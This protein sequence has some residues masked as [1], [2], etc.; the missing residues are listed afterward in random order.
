LS[1]ASLA[2]W[3][4]LTGRCAGGERTGI[5]AGLYALLLPLAHRY[6][7]SLLVDPFQAALVGA[8]LYS[9]VRA[10]KEGRSLLPVT[11]LVA[12]AGAAK[13]TSLLLAASLLL[14]LLSDLWRPA[15]EGR[16]TRSE[17]WL[18]ALLAL[19]PLLF[20]RR[21]DLTLLREMSYW[22]SLPLEWADLFRLVPVPL[23]IL[24]LLA[25]H[26]RCRFPGVLRGIFLF[27]LVWLAFFFWRRG[28]MNWL[29]PSAVPLAVL[30]AHA[31]IV[32]VGGRMRVIAGAGA[33]AALLYGGERSVAEIRA[34][35][36]RE[37]IYSEA[38]AFVDARVPPGG[39]IAVDALPFTGSV[40]LRT[41]T[42]DVR[43]TSFRD[44]SFA[45]LLPW[46]FE[47]YKIRGF[48]GAAWGEV[49]ETEVRAGWTLEKR[50]FLEGEPILEIYA[51]PKP[52]RR[53]R[54]ATSE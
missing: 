15:A 28:Q 50:Y 18:F 41:E 11:L 29:L 27:L 35:R 20:V 51:N 22:R 48:S 47:N 30:A 43:G 32:H 2:P 33:I 8:A 10:E 31:T 23:L 52:A 34:Y 21:G 40:Y 44:A 4:Y 38:G 54:G 24:A 25:P 53:S 37:R 3:A 45:L 26:P 5:L 7:T 19:S 16:R 39:I 49:H 6:G 46:V 42:C 12:A 17:P 9:F 1:S 36:A 14:V 13:Y